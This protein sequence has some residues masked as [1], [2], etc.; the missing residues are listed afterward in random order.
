MAIL[1][2]GMYHSNL[3]GAEHPSLHTERKPVNFR[4]SPSLEEQATATATMAK[5]ILLWL[6]FTILCST[7]EAVYEDQVGKFDW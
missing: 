5:L 1:A 6:K 7:I 2:G 4:L 3:Q